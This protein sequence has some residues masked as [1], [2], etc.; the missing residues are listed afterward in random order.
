MTAARRLIPTGP[1]LLV[2]GLLV[3]AA[4]LTGCSHASQAP[5]GKPELR[6]SGA[7]VPQPPMSDMAAGY[8]TVT[9]T[10]G[11][12]DE[13]TGVTSDLA[14]DVSMNTTT[15]AGQM[16]DAASLPIP[17]DGKLVLSTGG[18]HLMLMGLRKK[19][20]VGE[21]VSFVLHFAKSSPIAVQVPVEP[22]TYQPPKD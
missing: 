9:N 19:P 17:A 21:K 20:T 10:G 12:S 14:S 1:V 11:A 5:A 6:V 4:A 7:Y 13:L 16:Q 8:F 3:G 2:G 22:A 15:P 18:N